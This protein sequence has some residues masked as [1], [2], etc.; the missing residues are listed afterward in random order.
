[1]WNI[2]K[3]DE[4][5]W[6]QWK[7]CGAE[8]YLR[9][10][11]IEWQ[12]SFKALPF[13]KLEGFCGLFNGEAPSS[14][15]AV[16]SAWG[17]GEWVSLRPYLPT[18][19]F[20]TPRKPV[21]L[22]TGHEAHFTVDLPPLFKIECGPDLALAEFMPYTLSKAW[23]G[24]STSEGSLYLSL[25]HALK[26]LPADNDEHLA[27]LA[28]CTITVRNT[29]KTAFDL[30]YLAIYPR[31]LSVYAQDG[32][33]L[34][35]WLEFEYTGSDLKMNVKQPSGKPTLLTAGVKTDPGDEFLR[36]SMD[37]IHHIARF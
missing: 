8:A 6:Y 18:P 4:G 35:D 28:R 3:P 34:T 36:R 21:R 25:P 37:I 30:R 19:Y 13:Y 11:G 20:V 24:E 32:C 16:A 26:T 29:A 5:R 10:T 22:F 12:S 17:T 9:K 27:S 1:M 7:L 15:L 31:L 14:Q 23:F 2:F 33:L